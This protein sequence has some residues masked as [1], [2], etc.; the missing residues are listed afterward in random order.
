MSNKYETSLGVRFAEASTYQDAS[1]YKHSYRDYEM[2]PQTKMAVQPP[3][4]K[5]TYVEI[6][7]MDGELDLTEVLTGAPSYRSR[8][9]QFTFTLVDRSRWDY[10][11]SRLMNEIH[12]R[13]MRIVIDE[14]SRFYYTGRVKVNS[15]ASNK[16]TATIVVDAHLDPYK[17]STVANSE[18]W[19]WDPFNFESD[20]ARDYVDL[21]ASLNGATYTVVGSR[22][23][24]RPQ[25]KASAND[26][27]V[28]IDGGESIELPTSYGTP[29][30]IPALRDREY[31][32]TFTGNGTVNIR[33]AIGSL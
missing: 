25:F 32:M 2:F 11:Y 30:G 29:I 23:P 22:M 4:T 10:I 24:V 12:G 27:F 6:P 31:Q 7:G 17:I 28:S 8:D 26:I 20:I 14:D 16:N 13:R 1:S 9:A 5:E 21:D 19:L 3:E 15:F 18:R 33:F